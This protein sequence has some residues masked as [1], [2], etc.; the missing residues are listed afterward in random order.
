MTVNAKFQS[1]GYVSPGLVVHLLF[2]QFDARR[3]LLKAVKDAHKHPKDDRRLA[4]KAEG[5][6]FFKAGEEIGIDGIIDRQLQNAI[7]V[8]DADLVAADAAKPGM[9]RA[10][11]AARKGAITKARNRLRAAQEAAAEAEKKLQE[12]PDNKKEKAG[13][14]LEKAKAE[15]TAAEEALAKAEA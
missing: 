12:A 10:V 1:G 4:Y 14:T 15:V 5:M 3:H 6:L 2:G 8:D 13:L 9:K 7:A 11:S